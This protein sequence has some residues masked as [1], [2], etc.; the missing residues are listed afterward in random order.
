MS[1]EAQGYRIHQLRKKDISEFKRLV[2][3]YIGKHYDEIDETFPESILRTHFLGYDP[4]GYFTRRKTIWGL[5]KSTELIGF[6]VVTEKRG[7]S[8]KLGPTILREDYQGRGL[9]NLLWDFVEKTYS[10]RGFHKAY[11]TWPALR[12][13]VYK[14]VMRRGY[15]IEA[16]LKRHYTK[17]HDE[18]VAGKILIRVNNSQRKLPLKMFSEKKKPHRIAFLQ[19]NVDSA[20]LTSLT[21]FL[22]KNMS[23]DYTDID[24]VFV[25]NVLR[26]ASFFGSYERKGKRV[27]LSMDKSNE[28]ICVF[29]SVPKRGGGVKVT[30][31]CDMVS[32]TECA[33]R[34]LIQRIEEDYR[35]LGKYRKIYYIL[36]ETQISLY[37]IL[38]EESYDIEGVLKK[39]YSR[40]LDYV[41]LS[42]FLS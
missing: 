19:K 21:R 15:S 4:Y 12:L 31:V 7:G 41:L 26:S 36:P 42:K 8:I 24:E 1:A 9:G 11:T 37:K 32:A 33:A 28:I 38:K 22:I 17:K 35:G 5:Y 27:Y 34:S 39:A 23:S 10:I 6:V 40:S 3:K 2:L 13:D 30:P 20:L 18:L 16:Y 29:I 25:D 14:F